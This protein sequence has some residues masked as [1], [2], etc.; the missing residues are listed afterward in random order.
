MPDEK[1]KA[2]QP[3]PIDPEVLD[4]IEEQKRKASGRGP[5]VG[6]EERKK[7]ALA[8]AVLHAIRARDERAFS[9]ALRR[10]GVKDGSPEWR[11][12]W[13]IYRSGARG[14]QQLFSG[15]PLSFS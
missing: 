7:R 5:S 15:F 4:V 14:F 9:E 10:A 6:R 11:K 8:K 12:A 2:A 3:G 1:E 13:E